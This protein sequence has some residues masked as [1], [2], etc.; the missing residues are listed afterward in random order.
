MVGGGGAR[1][2]GGIRGVGVD[3][4]FAG[5]DLSALYIIE[6]NLAGV[7]SESYG[8]CEAAWEAQEMLFTT[9]CGS[10]R[11]RRAS[12]RWCRRGTTVRRVATISIRKLWPLS[13][14]AVSGLASTPYNVAVGG[15]DFDQV[16]KW[17]SY[18]RTQRTIADDWDVGAKLHSGNPVEPELRADWI[19]RMRHECAERIAEYRGGKRGA[20]Q[21]ATASPVGNWA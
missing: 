9:H 8:N 7:M 4:G 11:R 19:D 3:T 13:G 18:W 20:K 1:S 16:N 10:R 17:S 15:T 21:H 14:L 12:R 6:H 2:D 5:I